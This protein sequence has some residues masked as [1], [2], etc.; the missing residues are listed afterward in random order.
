M[1]FLIEL[2]Q[3]KCWIQRMLKPGQICSEYIYTLVKIQLEI[4]SVWTLHQTNT[5]LTGSRLLLEWSLERGHRRVVGSGPLPRIWQDFLRVGEN[6]DQFFDFLSRPVISSLEERKN[7]R[8]FIGLLHYYKV[9]Y[10]P[11]LMS[12]VDFA[13]KAWFIKWIYSELN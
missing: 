6:K 8:T 1:W 5:S 2:S 12:L 3:S 13:K 7:T 4:W 11:R 10:I 9:N